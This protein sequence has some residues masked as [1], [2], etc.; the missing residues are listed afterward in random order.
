MAVPIPFNNRSKW[1]IKVAI[2]MYMDMDMDMDTDI[3]SYKICLNEPRLLASRRFNSLVSLSD[4]RDLC[5][6]ITQDCCFTC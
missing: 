1:L 3:L 2:D 5:V 4:R 6:H